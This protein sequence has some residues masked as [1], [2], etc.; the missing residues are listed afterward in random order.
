LCYNEDVRGNNLWQKKHMNNA[1]NLSEIIKTE[2]AKIGNDEGIS[3]G[4]DLF[5]FV[6]AYRPDI[7][8]TEEECEKIYEDSLKKN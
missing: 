8:T 5:D 2:N 4:A 1:K 7:K 3:S 6:L